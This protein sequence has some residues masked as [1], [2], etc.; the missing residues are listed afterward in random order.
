[1]IVG[2]NPMDNEKQLL[3][4]MLGWGLGVGRKVGIR[5]RHWGL[6]LIRIHGI[7]F[8]KDE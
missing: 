7:N 4:V 6:D 8:Q 3:K 5:L 2:L 1:M